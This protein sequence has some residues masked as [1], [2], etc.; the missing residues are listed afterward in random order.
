MYQNMIKK[1][2]CKC[3]H[4][5]PARYRNGGMW[6]FRQN[7]VFDEEQIENIYVVCRD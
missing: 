6:L 7:V 4:C 3:S 1:G 2:M 5:M